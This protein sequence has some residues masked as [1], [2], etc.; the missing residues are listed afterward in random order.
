LNVE[1]VVVVAV[2]KFSFMVVLVVKVAMLAQVYVFKLKNTKIDD[3][4][5]VTVVLPKDTSITDG[6]C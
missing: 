6:K 4:A 5:L 2:V 1:V 3:V